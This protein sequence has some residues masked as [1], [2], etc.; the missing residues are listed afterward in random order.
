MVLQRKVIYMV[1]GGILALA[2]AFAGAAT[3]A[4]T[5]DDEGT[6][7][8]TVPEAESESDSDGE[9]VIVPR[10]NGR[11]DFEG[12]RGDQGQA[13]ADALGITLEELQAAKEE[14]RA[15]AIAQA[16][17]DGLLTQE[18]ADELLSGEGGFRGR[19]GYHL[20]NGDNKEFLAE[21]LGISVEELE[22]A[23][24]EVEAARLAAMVEAGIITQEQADMISAQ[25]AVAGY[26]DREALQAT[27]Q[28]AYEEAINQALEDGV[29][30]QEQADT[31]LSNA[32]NFGLRG[33]GGPGFGGPGFGG[34]G[35]HHGPRGGQWFAPFQDA[36]PSTTDTSADA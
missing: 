26:I 33:F 14:A 27:I 16:V 2:L 24:D 28:A 22:A 3:F 34:R 25:R 6:T 35:G 20:G 13:L 8:E 32:A 23:I 11:L 15:A 1:L 7:T 10:F 17:T 18:Q 21:A 9:T 36:Q 31:L 30:T 4:Q 5:D 29:I 12:V 19:P